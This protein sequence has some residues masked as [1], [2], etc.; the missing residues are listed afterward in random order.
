MKSFINITDL[1]SRNILA[2]GRRQRLLFRKKP[3]NVV[4]RLKEKEVAI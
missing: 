2:A 4:I 3:Q 1:R